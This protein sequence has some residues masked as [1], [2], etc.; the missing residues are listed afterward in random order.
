MVLYEGSYSERLEPWRHYVPLKKD[1]SN[2]EQVVSVL[3]SPERIRQITNCAYDEVA[4]AEHNGFRAM[5]RE[6]DSVIYDASV[7][8]T[9]ASAPSYTDRQILAVGSERSLGANW[10]LIKRWLFNTA[11]FLLFRGFLRV[12]SQEKRDQVHR[13]L[14]AKLKAIKASRAT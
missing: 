7:R 6:F 11:Y 14:L 8:C 2:F 10:L 3:R 12:I 1:H 5:V 4:G 9:R 13:W